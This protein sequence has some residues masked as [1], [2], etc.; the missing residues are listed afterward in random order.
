MVFR[1]RPL[2]YPSSA[3]S[4]VTSIKCVYTG[5][6]YGNSYV[7]VLHVS[8]VQLG[9]VSIILIYSHIAVYRYADDLHVISG[10]KM[11]YGAMSNS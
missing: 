10:T 6:E 3:S 9:R 4:C 5:N 2:V 1:R 7:H 11:M 8:R